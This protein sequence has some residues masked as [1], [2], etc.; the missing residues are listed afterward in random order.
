MLISSGVVLSYSGSPSRAAPLAIE[1]AGDAVTEAYPIATS[2]KDT[3]GVP[4]SVRPAVNTATCMDGGSGCA[5]SACDTEDMIGHAAPTMGTLDALSSVCSPMDATF[6]YASPVDAMAAPTP[7]VPTIGASPVGSWRVCRRRIFFG[8]S[9]WR[10]PCPPT[11]EGTWRLA[12]DKNSL[13]Q[14]DKKTL[15]SP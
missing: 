8:A 3:L 7:L 14:K 6:G 15:D 4:P 10:V 1:G 12:R 13:R 9:H 5:S 11:L 2:T